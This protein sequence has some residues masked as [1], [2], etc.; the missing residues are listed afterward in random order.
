MV[1]W[2]SP[3]FIEHFRNWEDSVQVIVEMHYSVLGLI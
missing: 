2:L 1:N 3:M